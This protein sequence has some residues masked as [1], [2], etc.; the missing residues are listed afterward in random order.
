MS[1]NF[2]VGNSET[3]FKK[4]NLKYFKNSYLRYAYFEILQKLSLI[5]FYHKRI[6]HPNKI[7][8]KDANSLN[9]SLPDNFT[10]STITTALTL[11]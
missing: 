5:H 10:Q 11:I 2:K 3:F 1:N 9:I 8:T 7:L 4:R 6:F